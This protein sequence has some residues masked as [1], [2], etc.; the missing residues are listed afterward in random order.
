MMAVLAAATLA[1]G[2]G[3]AHAA[4]PKP[5]S[6]GVEASIPFVNYGGIWNWQADGDSALYIQDQHRQWYHATL[7]SPCTDLPFALTVGFRSP[8]VDQLDRFSSIQVGHQQCQIQSLVTSGSPPVKGKMH[9]TK[10]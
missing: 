10:S 4:P 9:K 3:A 7:M 5:R 8:G 6:L 2:G 1:I